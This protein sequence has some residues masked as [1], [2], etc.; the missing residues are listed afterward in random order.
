MSRPNDIALS[1]RRYPPEL[2]EE[3]RALTRTKLLQPLTPEEE[4]R[5]AEINDQLTA[6]D[7]TDPAFQAWKAEC[8]AMQERLAHIRRETEAAPRAHR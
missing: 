4:I 1:E 2:L 8:D 5:L 7:R 3:Y 6:L